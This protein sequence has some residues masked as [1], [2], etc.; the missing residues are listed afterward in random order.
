M[1]DGSTP[2][3]PRRSPVH[4][5][6]EEIQTLHS[7][8]A[9]GGMDLARRQLPS[10]TRNAVH[11]AAIR[12]GLITRVPLEESDAA[13]WTPDEDEVL[14]RHYGRKLPAELAAQYLFRTRVAINKRASVLGLQ[15]L[16]PRALPMG[17]P[18]TEAELASVAAASTHP[19]G[20][21][22]VDWALLTASLPGRSRA[23]IEAQINKF[24]LKGGP[25]RPARRP[26]SPQEDERIR[27]EYAALGAPAMASLLDRSIPAVLNRAYDL[28]VTR[29]HRP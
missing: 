17:T 24:R 15:V 29:P 18:W 20:A 13:P 21:R 7:A 19:T 27:N 28:G 16:R 25:G 22:R 8:F 1:A 3:R 5:T 4:W 6:E 14:R 12:Q 11:R 9:A 26:W 2:N 23:S 10:R